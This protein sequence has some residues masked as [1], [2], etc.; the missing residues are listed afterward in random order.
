[1]RKITQS[2]LED[3]LKK[4]R[5]NKKLLAELRLGI[6]DSLDWSN[7]DFL[8]LSNKS[9][10]KGLLFYEED[11]RLTVASYKIIRKTASQSGQN[12]AMICDICN[13]WQRGEA[14]GFMTIEDPSNRQRITGCYVCLNLECS[15]H[16]RDLTNQGLLSRTQ[17]R[18]NLDVASRIARLHKNLRAILRA[19]AGSEH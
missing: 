3:I 4:G 12:K 16:I 14:V 9:G 19:G 10:G 11:D 13:T 6:L 18:E 7:L 2:Q 15:L 1:M 5:Y 17:L 8:T